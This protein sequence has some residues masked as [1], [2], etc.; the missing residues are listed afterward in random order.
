MTLFNQ[1]PNP[2]HMRANCGCAA[3]RRGFLSGLL[4]LGASA[5][6]PGCTS[7]GSAVADTVRKVLKK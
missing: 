4:A 2:N 1:N 7:T 3:P 6:L 5:A